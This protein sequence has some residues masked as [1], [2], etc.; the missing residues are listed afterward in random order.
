MHEVTIPLAK[1]QRSASRRPEIEIDRILVVD[2]QAAP[3]KLQSLELLEQLCRGGLR[4]VLIKK[5]LLGGDAESSANWIRA[6]REMTACALEVQWTL[7]PRTS[8]ELRHL[9]H[10]TPPTGC[11]DAE[12]RWASEFRFGAL[13]WR[14]GPNFVVVKDARREGISMLALDDPPSHAAFFDAMAGAHS[15]LAN[16]PGYKELLQE[17]VLLNLGG[18]LITLPYRMRHWPVP[19][20]AV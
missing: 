6:L 16:E 11:S 13:Y 7:D 3:L 18:R 9:H 4:T 17:G 19:F 15:G 5:S 10:L 12:V 20:R 14:R 1:L 8:I 2:E